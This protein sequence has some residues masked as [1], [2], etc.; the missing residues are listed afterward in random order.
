MADINL[1]FGGIAL[2]ISV[3][4]L[5]FLSRQVGLNAEQVR[6]AT[7]QN[8]VR[9]LELIYANRV[10]SLEEIADENKRKI[11]AL[12]TQLEVMTRIARRH[13]GDGVL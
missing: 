8:N 1:V 12:E 3:I 4:T 13:D 6:A 5:I 2:F 11:T 9:E 7:Q 10:A